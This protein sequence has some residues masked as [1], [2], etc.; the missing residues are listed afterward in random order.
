MQ[1]TRSYRPAVVVATAATIYILAATQ[2]LSPP[3]VA[4]EIM[5]DLSL[6]TS[7]MSL[8]F[9]MTMITYAVMQPVVGFWSDCFGPRRCLLTAALVLGLGS[10][11]FSMADGLALGMAS[12]TMVGLAAGMALMPCM[13][14]AG[15]WFDPKSFRLASALIISSAA[16]ANFAVGR[17]LAVASDNFG[18]RA[19]FV[20]LGLIG[21]LL[22]LAVFA[23][24]RDHPPRTDEN[25]PAEPGP[26][27]SGQSFFKNAVIIV[28]TPA[29]WLL[30]LLYA[31]T[32][33]PYG[34]FTGL[35]AGPYLIEV[36]GASEVLVGNMLS[37]S[38]VGFLIGPPILII[39]A[40]RLNSLIT[41]LF[42]ICIINILIVDGMIMRLGKVSLFILMGVKSMKTSLGVRCG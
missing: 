6:N 29:F 20:A 17:P 27:P 36:H 35:W 30:G 28:K 2:R 42:G 21:L 7:N 38:A 12:R 41:V 25:I 11:A 10:L 5:N 32:D 13:K 19:S 23:I 18:W 9:A 24:V 22:A 8:M 16:L 3:V 1:R 26:K 14:L 37:V 34:A 33:M 40:N 4:L 39:L 15:N 31:L